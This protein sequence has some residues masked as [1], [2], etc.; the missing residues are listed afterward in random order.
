[1]YVKNECSS[2]LKEPSQNRKQREPS[3]S[4]GAQRNNIQTPC[5]GTLSMNNYTSTIGFLCI[6]RLYMRNLRISMIGLQVDS[7]EGILVQSRLRYVSSQAFGQEPAPLPP[8]LRVSQHLGRLPPASLH[9][10]SRAATS[11]QQRTQTT[12]T[13][14][15]SYVAPFGL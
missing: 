6:H 7:K 5:E 4:S 12:P 2:P 10:R 15:N 11:T 8:E 13:R 3:K 1:M 9:L 14:R